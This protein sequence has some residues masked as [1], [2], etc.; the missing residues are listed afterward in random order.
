MDLADF[1]RPTL[2]IVDAYRVLMRNGPTGGNV[3]DT[4]LKKSV[5][6][7]TDPVAIDAYVA[8]AFWNLDVDRLRYLKLAQDRG[9]GRLNFEALRTSIVSV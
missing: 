6:A 7:S 9:L 8:K 1:M 4:S 5:V 2:T 3:S